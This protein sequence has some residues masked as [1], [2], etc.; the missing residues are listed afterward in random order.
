MAPLYNRTNDR[1]IT[2]ND[3]YTI[4]KKEYIQYIYDVCIMNNFDYMAKFYSWL[5]KYNKI[6]KDIASEGYK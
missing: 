6:S 2:R 1:I 3:L 5:Y 4:L